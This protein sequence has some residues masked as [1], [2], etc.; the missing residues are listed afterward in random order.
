MA[1][2]RHG[3]FTF[4]EGGLV[5]D[6]EAY[7]G[8]GVNAI[9]GEAGPEAVIPLDDPDAVEVMAEA[10]EEGGAGETSDAEAAEAVAE[11]AEEVA[12]AATE[13]AEASATVAEASAEIVDDVTDV[14]ERLADFAEEATEENAEVAEEAVEAVEEIAEHSEDVTSEVVEEAEP[15]VEV[16]EAP[17][18]DAAP[19]KRHWSQVTL[20][21]LLGSKR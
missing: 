6:E 10:I 4:A 13:I 2:V 19:R 14:L 16:E 15:E 20:G 9:V 1:R 12:E 11:A 8:P 17:K 7:D 5:D 3:R 18:R 21:E